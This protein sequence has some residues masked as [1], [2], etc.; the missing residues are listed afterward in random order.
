MSPES[1][2]GNDDGAA[3]VNEVIKEYPA[4]DRGEREEW[5]AHVGWHRK[6]NIRQKLRG[7]N[8][9]KRQWEQSTNSSS[10]NEDHTKTTLVPP[11]STYSG[12]VYSKVFLLLFIIVGFLRFFQTTRHQFTKRGRKTR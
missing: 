3:L 12:A 4:Q 9:N 10:L 7:T 1:K 8:I 11:P 5:A 6:E 2:G